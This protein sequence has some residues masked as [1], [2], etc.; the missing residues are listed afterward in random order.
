MEN[1][2]SPVHHENLAETVYTRIRQAIMSGRLSP[3]ERLIHRSLAL[4]LNVSPTPIRDA[5]RRLVSDGALSMDDRGVATVPELSPERYVEIIALRLELEGKSAA[6]A[7][8]HAGADVANELARLHAELD[9]AKA[10]G[11]KFTALEINE[12]FH[13]TVVSAANMPVLE[14][15]VKSLWVQCGPSLQFLHTDDFVPLERHPHLDLIDA[16]RANDPTRAV[17]AVWDD[18][19]K[20]GEHVLRKL[21]LSSQRSDYPLDANPWLEGAAWR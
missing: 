14:G 16:I 5:V 1:P 3:G 21:C 8:R 13:L 12:R 17:A 18:L 15:L 11:N 6:K 7:A 4:E 20:N 9:A 10:A 19:V 2:I